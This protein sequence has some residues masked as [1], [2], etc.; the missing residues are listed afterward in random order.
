MTG[1]SVAS[2]DAAVTSARAASASAI[3][4]TAG[5][6]L[7]DSVTTL[8]RWA[9]RHDVQT[10]VMRRAQSSLPLSHVWLLARIASC[11]PCHPSDLAASFGVDNSTI[12]PK[13]Q[14]LESEELVKRRP[15]PTDR[16][17]ALVETTPSGI[18]LLGRLR[19]AR[20]AILEERLAALP[21]PRR[22]DV[23]TA[24]SDLA[25]ILE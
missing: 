11:G 9:T 15:D 7:E 16:R 5:S 10:A 1:S 19:R 18:R 6:G 4:P 17:A 14:R 2:G 24:L 3:G 23:V 25:S 21:Q 13:L 8:V 12:T 20:A 22:L